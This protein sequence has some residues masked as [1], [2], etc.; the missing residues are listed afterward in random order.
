MTTATTAA[1]ERFRTGGGEVADTAQRSEH[2]A[3]RHCLPTSSHRERIACAMHKNRVVILVGLTGTGK[4]TQVPQ[5]L[6]EEKE[7]RRRGGGGG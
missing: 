5:F 7:E 2:S 4:S 1:L 6:L 3:A